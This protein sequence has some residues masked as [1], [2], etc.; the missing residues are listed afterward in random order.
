MVKKHDNIIL[1]LFNAIS[2]VPVI[3]IRNIEPYQYHKP[4]HLLY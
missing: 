2:H 4:S 3:Q 1:A